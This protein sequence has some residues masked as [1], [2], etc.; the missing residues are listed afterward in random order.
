MNKGKLGIVMTTYSVVAFVLALT[1][2]L[3]LCALLLGFVLVY[4]KDEYTSR[5]CL[6]A[7]FLSIA[8]TVFG[9]VGYGFL[10]GGMSVLNIIPNLFYRIGY[11]VAIFFGVLFCLCVLA[12]VVFG[13]IGLVNVARRKEAGVPLFSTLAYKAFGFMKPKPQIQPPPAAFN[14][15]YQQNYQPGYGQPP[16]APVSGQP[17]GYPGAPQQG[18]APPPLPPPTYAALQP[19]EPPA[20]T[21]PSYEASGYGAAAP[22]QPA[23]GEKG[24]GEPPVSY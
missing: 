9:S 18:I 19:P 12:L 5:Q 1:G 21:L 2:Q 17:M 23:A 20:Y 22:G 10:G 3:L 6:T 16:E 15:T 13:V 14:P 8:T 11:G 7:F 24:N 4:E